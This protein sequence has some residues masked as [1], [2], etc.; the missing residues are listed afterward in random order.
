M[1]VGWV[2]RRTET[3]VKEAGTTS[4]RSEPPTR[5]RPRPPMTD[6]SSL[7]AFLDPTFLLNSITANIICSIAFGQS[8]NYQDSRFLRL[9][10]LQNDIFA[11]ISSL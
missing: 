2:K 10:H 11:I 3:Q 5:T 6:L 9:L 8:F 4:P 1:K 7:G